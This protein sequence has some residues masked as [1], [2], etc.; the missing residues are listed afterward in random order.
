MRDATIREIKPEDSPRVAELLTQLGYP[1]TAED[2]RQRLVYWLDDPLSRILVAERDTRVI[3]SLSLHA[4]PY[5]ER[6]GRWAR[7]ESLVVDGAARR[8]GVARSLLQAAEDTA[9]QWGCLAVEITSAR[10]RDDA[11]A[12]YKKLGYTDVCDKSARFFK[13]LD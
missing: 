12:F 4:I 9:R 10:Y 6:T 5:L 13:L 7:V 11:H 2:V 3:G 8:G 1:A